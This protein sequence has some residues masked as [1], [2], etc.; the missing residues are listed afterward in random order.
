MEISLQQAADVLG[1]TE[2]EVLFIVQDGRMQAIQKE[3][4]EIKY[5][6][7]GRIEFN[8]EVSQ[9]AWMFDFNEVL[10]VKKELEESLDGQLKVLLE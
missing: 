4:T 2:D 1:K 9:P 6:A 10:R 8:D 3:D 7:D 5:L